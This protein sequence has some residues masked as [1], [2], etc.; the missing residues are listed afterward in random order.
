MQSPDDVNNRRV[1]QLVEQFNAE[2]AYADESRSVREEWDKLLA[3]GAELT[4]LIGALDKVRRKLP[5][6]PPV[7]AVGLWLENPAQ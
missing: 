4:A 2:E 1:R 5:K 6:P 3:S 7:N